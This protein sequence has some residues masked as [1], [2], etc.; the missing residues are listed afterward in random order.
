MAKYYTKWKWITTCEMG[1]SKY[2]LFNTEKE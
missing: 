2:G 1:I